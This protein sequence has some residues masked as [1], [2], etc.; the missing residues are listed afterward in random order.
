MTGTAP[1]PI[2]CAEMELLIQADLDGELD[3]AAT[4]VLS[5]HL[6]DCPGCA[7]LQAELA[8]LGRDLRGALRHEAAPTRL[9]AL[10]ATPPAAVIAPRRWR[11]PALS[12][13]AGAAIA[14][15]LVLLL[16]HPDADAGLA[17]ELVS[18]HIRALQP[19]HLLDVPSSDH[20]TV[21]PWFEGR[22]DFAPPVPDFA[23][24][25]FA[26][27]GGRLDIVGGRTV[28]V[29]I[30]RH[31]KHLLNVFVWPGTPAASSSSRQ[32]F[33]LRQWT[34]GGL[35]FHAVSDLDA[36]EFDRFVQLWQGAA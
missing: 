29:L 20:H 19:G 14:A 28:A 1:N 17:A 9:R 31:D 12:F 2:A 4:A 10:L 32:G 35:G 36:G 27:E 18:D 5:A 16:P 21:K 3:A 24:D 8:G 7:A 25:G 26:L 11:L 33:G 34:Q 23:A 15:S 30:Y 6:Q 22:I 13:A